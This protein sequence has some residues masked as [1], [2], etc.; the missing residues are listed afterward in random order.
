MT[1]ILRDDEFYSTARLVD[2]IAGAVRSDQPLPTDPVAAS[3]L[4]AALREAATEKP[5]AVGGTPELAK[6]ISGKTYQLNENTLR[7]K[8]FVLNFFNSDSSWEI[9]TD[10]GKSE[11][12]TQRFSGLMGLDGIFR[13]S[14]PAFYGINA[15]KG[16][17]L[18]E[19]TFALERRI[20]GHS[21]TQRWVLAF[22][23]DKVTVNFE[24]T[25]G[26]K[27]ELHGARSD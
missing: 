17:W 7:I 24:N 10:T 13:K 22:E 4:A 19:H 2:D 9:T 11:Q 16:R 20:L 8:T 23:D 6:A 25:D 14:P 18:N 26:A 27:A 3:L 5:S 1:G 12:P 21:E 15:A